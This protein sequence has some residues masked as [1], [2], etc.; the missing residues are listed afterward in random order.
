MVRYMSNG[1][2]RTQIV[3]GIIDGS[4]FQWFHLCW[5]YTSTENTP[6]P[7]DGNSTSKFYIDGLLKDT[8]A[9][10]GTWMDITNDINIGD[11]TADEFGTGPKGWFDDIRFYDRVFDDSEVYQLWSP[12]TRF[13]LYKYDGIATGVEFDWNIESTAGGALVGG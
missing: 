2:S 3:T 4:D 6:G 5:T 12:N 7:T 10:F 8:D 9:D 1:F 11:G 13:D